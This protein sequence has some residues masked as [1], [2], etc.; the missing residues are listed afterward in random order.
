[1]HCPTGAVLSL[2]SLEDTFYLYY[3]LIKYKMTTLVQMSYCCLGMNHDCIIWQQQKLVSVLEP[4][5]WFPASLLAASWDLYETLSSS[6]VV[7]RE[8]KAELW[9]PGC[10]LSDA[11]GSHSFTPAAL[12]VLNVLT[13]WSCRKPRSRRSEECMNSK[14][15]WLEA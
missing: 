15:L 2:I 6:E 9:P 11:R 3:C 14:D 12:H 1:M 7:N 10:L 13:G 5:V 8:V 4:R